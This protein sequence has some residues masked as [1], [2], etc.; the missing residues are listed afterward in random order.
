MP[1]DAD[2]LIKALQSAA[3]AA[4]EK[5]PDT[6]GAAVAA[7]VIG[8]L[9]KFFAEKFNQL[10]TRIGELENAPFVYDGPHEAGKTYR[11][12]MFT[13]HAGSLWHCNYTT[14]SRP[15][16]GPAWTLAVKRGKD[17]KEQ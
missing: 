1:I 2:K 7:V 17:G 12:G 8:S 15:G 13:T 14:A 4:A 16:D 5:N 9:A 10:E 3:L 11:K 6:N